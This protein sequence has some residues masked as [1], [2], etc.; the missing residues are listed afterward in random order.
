MR[1]WPGSGTQTRLPGDGVIWRRNGERTRQSSTDHGVMVF[2]NMQERPSTWFRLLLDLLTPR[3]IFVLVLWAR[4]QC[5]MCSRMHIHTGAYVTKKKPHHVHACSC[6]H[7]TLCPSSC[8]TAPIAIRPALSAT[9]DEPRSHRSSTPSP[10]PARQLRALWQLW[11][12]AARHGSWRTRRPGLGP[13]ALAAG[14]M[15]TEPHHALGL[16]GCCGAAAAWACA[17]PADGGKRRAHARP[18]RSVQV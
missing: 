14:G 10:T 7:M 17:P 15:C 8:P 11:A 3:I 2:L 18:G 5:H 6:R 16:R 13:A 9:T 1:R 4:V 12:L